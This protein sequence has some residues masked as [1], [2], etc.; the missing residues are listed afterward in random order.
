MT[1]RLPATVG[2]QVESKTTSGTVIVDDQRFS[3]T[4]QTVR[5]S[6]GPSASALRLHTSS[7]SGN[8]AVVHHQAAPAQSFKDQP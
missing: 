1:V 2:V 8:V 4:A 3:G 5:T 6:S 7:V